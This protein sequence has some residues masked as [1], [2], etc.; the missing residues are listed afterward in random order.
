MLNNEKPIPKSNKVASLLKPKASLFDK[1]A[2]AY[3]AWF[4]K[5]G[6]LI[7]ETEVRAF[8]EILSLLPKPWLEIGVGSGR[9]A[10]ALGI[11]TGV[12][13][14]IEL[15]NIARSRGITI[16]QGK[17]EEEI[18]KEESF[19]TVFL[20]VTLC[21]VDSPEAVLREAHRILKLGG[22]VVLGLVL[23]ENPWGEF[24]EQK[25]KHGHRFYKYATFYKCDEVT[26]LLVQA[27]FVTERIISTLFQEPDKVHHVE[28]PRQG[29]SPNAGFTIIVGTKT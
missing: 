11:E 7:F 15:L 16:I 17:G 12:D 13:P 27:G 21:F 28:E 6:K 19:S 22:K 1:L 2:S 26:K 25:K 24:Y 29:Y 8:Q 20:I 9:F 4:E 18:F 23:K 10:W 14:S 3:D 5:D